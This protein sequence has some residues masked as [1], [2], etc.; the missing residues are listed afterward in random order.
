[1]QESSPR[2]AAREPEPTP[3]SAPAPAAPA[4]PK[5]KIAEL[6]GPLWRAEA[7]SLGFRRVSGLFGIQMFAS[8]GV[9]SV[10][11]S[12]SSGVGTAFGRQGA[13]QD[14]VGGFTFGVS[15]VLGLPYE[16]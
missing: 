16:P 15:A 10:Q 5:A 14:L 4:E 2:I 7:N 6:L 13:E 11:C 9:H 8:F 12:G 3:I 1:M